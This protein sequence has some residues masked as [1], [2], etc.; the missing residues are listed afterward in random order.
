VVYNSR[1]FN[2][3]N[4]WSMWS[5]IVVIT[6]GKCATHVLANWK[7]SQLN[8]SSVERVWVECHV[9]ESNFLSH[10]GGLKLGLKTLSQKYRNWGELRNELFYYI[11]WTFHLQYIMNSPSY[12]K[13][14]FQYTRIFKTVWCLIYIKYDGTDLVCDGLGSSKSKII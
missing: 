3:F 11:K 8:L 12:R 9:A 1:L 10:L 5:I 13:S 14:T 2:G 4:K 7:F 6:L